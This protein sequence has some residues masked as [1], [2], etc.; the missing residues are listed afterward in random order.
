MRDDFENEAQ[1]GHTLL[2]R[3][4]MVSHGTVLRIA[5][6]GG[7]GGGER[8]MPPGGIKAWEDELAVEEASELLT[9]EHF[10]PL[11]RACRTE[12]QY[13]TVAD[14]IAKALAAWQRASRPQKDTRAWREQIGK[15]MA[16]RD[17]RRGSGSA[18]A[19]AKKWRVSKK[20][21]YQYEQEYLRKQGVAA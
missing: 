4:E 3:L 9:H 10:R 21:A 11:L 19:I 2:A 20:S 16:G 15:E 5:G 8:V 6:E 7:G 18:E 12:T 17:R 13:A 1:R 14:E